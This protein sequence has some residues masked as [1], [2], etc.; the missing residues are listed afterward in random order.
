MLPVN[1]SHFSYFLGH[2]SH[3]I[4]TE[5]LQKMKVQCN[6]AKM[7]LQQHKPVYD[8]FGGARLER[9]EPLVSGEALK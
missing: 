1:I 3:L 7:F 2:L 6:N 9:C 8:E 5:L 4:C